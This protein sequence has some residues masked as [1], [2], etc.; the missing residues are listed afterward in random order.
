VKQAYTTINMRRA[1]IEMIE[2]INVIIAEYLKAGFMLTV[3]QLYYQLVA[4]DIIPNTIQ[5]YK[6]ITGLVNDGRMCGLIDWDVIEDR[7]R[8]VTDRSKWTDANSILEACASSFHMD[9]WENQEHRVMIIVEKEALAGVMQRICHE[10]SMPMLAAR[11]YPSVTVIRD[12]ALG[13]IRSAARAGQRVKILHLGDHDPSGLDMTRDLEDR[14]RIFQPGFAWSIQR[15]ALNM[16]QVDEKGL[17]ENPAKT[18]DSRFAQY[19]ERFGESSWELDALEPQYLV[20]LVRKHAEEFI[21]QDAWAAK[22]AEIA[23]VK[24]KLSWVAENFDNLDME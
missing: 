5:S 23:A 15:I 8:E 7:T 1:S 18:T 10:L 19:A 22:E 4:R 13:K 6:N 3:R 16:D 20:D 14:L 12:L 2:R 21:D 9:M 24:E 17:P 11:G